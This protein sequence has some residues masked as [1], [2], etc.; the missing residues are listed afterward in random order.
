MIN[1]GFH[2]MKAKRYHGFAGTPSNFTFS[3]RYLDARPIDDDINGALCY[4]R[5]ALIYRIAFYFAI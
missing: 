3:R 4:S 1:A 5:H 2:L